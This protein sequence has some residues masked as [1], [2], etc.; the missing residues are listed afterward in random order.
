M[1]VSESCRHITRS[2]C[3]KR[4]ECGARRSPSVGPEFHTAPIAFD[5]PSGGP[6]P[7]PREFPLCRF[8]DLKGYRERLLM[9]GTVLSLQTRSS[10]P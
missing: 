9:D 10:F 7:L 8:P 2:V 1:L 5:N 4:F 3:P 6:P